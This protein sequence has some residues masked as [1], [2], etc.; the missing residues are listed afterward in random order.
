MNRSNFFFLKNYNNINEYNSTEV[1]FIIFISNAFTHACLYTMINYTYMYVHQIK[2]SPLLDNPTVCC[3]L[4]HSKY[5]CISVF[6]FVKT[7]S[8]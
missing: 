8:S 1:F 2:R 5:M 4:F 3:I 7:H 6:N